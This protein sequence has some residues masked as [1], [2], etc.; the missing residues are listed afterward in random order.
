[1]KLLE[2]LVVVFAVLCPSALT[3]ADAEFFHPHY[4]CE[5]MRG[6]GYSYIL[7]AP[8]GKILKIEEAK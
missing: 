2:L 3:G 1:M 4:P 8:G 7:V 6:G 5:I